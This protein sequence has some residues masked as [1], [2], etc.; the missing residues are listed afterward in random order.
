V[1][2]LSPAMQ[3]R[4]LR[5]LQERE[6]RRVGE[7]RARRVDVRVLAATHRNLADEVAAG[8][9]RQDLYYRLRVVEVCIP[10]LRARRADVLPLARAVLVRLAARFKR[11]VR[12]LSPEAA[13]MLLRY[14]WPGNVRELENALERAVVLAEGPRVALH[15]LPEDQR[16]SKPGL[17]TGLNTTRPLRPYT[18][19][20]DLTP[21]SARPSPCQERGSARR[22]VGQNGEV[23][24]K[25]SPASHQRV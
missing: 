18:P 21:A 12:S 16:Y 22:S 17:L 5:V 15:D 6:V 14:R 7:T 25:T 3:V 19:D 24:P 10:P 1:G 11:P 8:R 4:L 20:G 13:D 2:E 23:F 9:F